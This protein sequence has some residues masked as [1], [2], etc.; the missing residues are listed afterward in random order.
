MSIMSCGL[1]VPTAPALLDPLAI[2]AMLDTPEYETSDANSSPYSAVT[3]KEN[4]L[5]A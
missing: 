5:P 3:A 1:Y 4:G 2:S